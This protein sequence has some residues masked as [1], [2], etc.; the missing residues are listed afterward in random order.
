LLQ[1][2]LLQQHVLC[3]AS[4]VRAWSAVWIRIQLLWHDS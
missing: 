4:A 2:D 3:G 1:S